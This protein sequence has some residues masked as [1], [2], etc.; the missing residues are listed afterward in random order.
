MKP[1]DIAKT[2]FTVEGV[3]EF[4][5]MPF[6]LKNAP[7]TF[8]WVMDS[9]LGDLNGTICLVY[10]DDIIIFLQ[11]HLL[12]IKMVFEKLR[13]ANFKVQPSQ[14]EFLR[15]EKEF[16]GHIVT[17]DGIK[18]NPNK[19]SAIKK[20]PCPTNR[21][22]IKSFLG[23]L[24]YYRKFIRDFARITKPKTKQLK[25]KRQV[26]TDKDFV[27]A[28]EQCK[29]IFSHDPILIHPDFEKPFILTTD[30]SNFA[31]GAVLSQTNPLRHRSQL[32]N[33]R[34]RNVGNNMGS[35]IF[36]TIYLWRKIYYC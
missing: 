26:T 13:A 9:V 31:L 18:P 36:Q 21:K 4:I 23:L 15:K 6:G 5:R 33:H 28:F 3:Y 25:G 32:F 10:L 19:I 14:S 7:A 16:L 22:A 34:K 27:D 8:Q 20:F 24:G 2:A 30:A 11:K 1:K 35:K 29:T 17:Q 12:D